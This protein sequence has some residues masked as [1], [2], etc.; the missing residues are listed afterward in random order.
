MP[1]LAVMTRDRRTRLVAQ[2][3]LAIYVMA[4][5]FSMA[6]S[7]A[8]GDGDHS[9]GSEP[10]VIDHYTD[11]TGKTLTIAAAPDAAVPQSVGEQLPSLPSLA[12]AAP[13]RAYLSRAP[14]RHHE[15]F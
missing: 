3:T 1:R 14:P 8:Y 9:H 4:G 7:A 11:D 10:C 2:L 13:A 6:H 15:S 12:E 5:A